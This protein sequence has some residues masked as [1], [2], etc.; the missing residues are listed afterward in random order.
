MVMASAALA[1]CCIPLWAFAHGV[2]ALALGVFFMQLGVQ[3]AWGVIPAH[4]NELSPAEARGTFPGVTYQLGNLVAAGVPQ[5]EA[6]L[7]VKMP[8]PNGEPNYAA[9]LALVAF[10]TLA[11]ACALA[12][13][14]H[15][16]RKETRGLNFA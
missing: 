4:L 6:V 14:G 7:A 12:V 8:L 10:I 1:A 13:I 3:G 11:C 2:A 9:A 15:F 16:V 5:L